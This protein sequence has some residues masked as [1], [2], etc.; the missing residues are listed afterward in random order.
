MPI[1]RFQLPDGRVARFEVPDGTTPEQAQS[2]MAQAMGNQPKAYNPTDDM[3]T[4]QRL[5]AGIGQGM[6]SAGRAF[7]Q[8]VSK[9]TGAED[10]GAGLIK[11]SEIDDAKK[12]DAALLATRS[13]SIG[14]GLGKVA[15]AAP[16]A[17]LPGANTYMG[18]AL[19]GG[20]TG[21]AL[22]EGDAAERAKAALGGAVGGAAGKG[23]GDLLG[24]GIPKAVDKLRA[25]REA[26]QV[27]NAQRDAA[28]LAAKEAGYVLPP[29]DVN[30]SLINEALGGLSGK[31]KTAQA[32]SAKNQDVTNALAKKALGIADD[33]PLNV[34]ALAEVRKQAGQVYEAVKGIGTVKADAPYI[35][36]LDGL[37]AQYEGAAKDFPG[38]AKGEITSLVESLKRPEFDASSAVDAVRVLRETADKAFRAGDTGLGKT[39]K[40]AA[41]EMESLLERNLQSSGAPADLISAFRDARQ[42]IAKTYTVQ[43][44]LNN[45]TGDVSAQALASL[46]KKGKPLSGEL[47]TAAKAGAAFPKAT[48]SLKEAPKAWSPLDMVAGSAGMGMGSP[49]MVAMAAA[50]PGVRSLLLSKGYQGLL[51]NP[52]TYQRGL[53]EASL[54]ALDNEL[55][56]RSLPFGGGLLGVQ[57]SQ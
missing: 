44:A 54:P 30:P 1:A 39:A 17:L 23:L 15:V 32:A 14:S 45:E 29:A 43:K 35:K 48:Q 55:V 50:R 52:Q 37:K 57:L 3:G 20:G 31:I 42:T 16:T 33:A 28:A 51:A 26:A 49:A 40:A 53:L 13:G 25:G 56:K 11:Q 18:A 27:A 2:M 19:I 9:L 6:S 34:N 46:L 5:L 47:E 4:G 24:W 36:A 10:V 22:T 41:G 12:N 7:L 21:A 8:G 38:L